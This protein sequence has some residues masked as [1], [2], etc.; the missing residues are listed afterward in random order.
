MRLTIAEVETLLRQEQPLTF[1]TLAWFL[2]AL[3]D[4]DLLSEASDQDRVTSV[5]SQP[6]PLPDLVTATLYCR[7]YQAWQKRRDH[8][9][10]L[11]L[12]GSV[13]APS[14]AQH[15]LSTTMHG[16]LR[17]ALRPREGVNTT[18][19]LM[20]YTSHV[21]REVEELAAMVP[22]GHFLR[23]AT[24]APSVAAPPAAPPCWLLEAPRLLLATA[25]DLGLSS[26]QAMVTALS[27]VPLAFDA[28]LLPLALSAYMISLGRHVGPSVWL[29][30]EF[31]DETWSPLHRARFSANLKMTVA[32]VAASC[33]RA[34]NRRYAEALQL[35]AFV[36]ELHAQVRLVRHAALWW[37]VC[38]CVACVC[39]G[40]CNPSAGGAWSGCGGCGGLFAVA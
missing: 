9:T 34:S 27:T 11:P 15:L 40:G 29:R 18:V 24:L 19:P 22:E 25:M 20:D 36:P 7:G 37:T 17:V 10:M 33:S 35:V 1:A 28:S 3:F 31:F 26:A 8:E 32:G 13:F 2:S 4:T 30:K 5:I 39:V 38:A 6:E 23:R 21:L 14:V 16:E 12:Y